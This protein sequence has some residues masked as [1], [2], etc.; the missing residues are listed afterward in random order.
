MIKV[1]IADDMELL[2]TA[3]VSLLRFEEDI[4]VVAEAG[5]GSEV[6]PAARRTRP[7][8]AVIDV[9]MPGLDGIAAAGQLRS[10]VPDCRTIIMTGVSAPGYLERALAVDAHGFLWKNG[11]PDRFSTA[12]RDVAAGRRVIDSEAAAMALKPLGTSPVSA[13]ELEAL[14][15]AAEGY[16]TGEIAAALHIGSGTARNHLSSAV[17]KLGGRNRLDAV[18]LARQAGLL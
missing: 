15:L 6:V 3:L 18:R 13:R 11:D 1:L 12:I 14:R 16:R 2:R 5:A 9:L 4:E 17:T 7:D 10:A 8:V